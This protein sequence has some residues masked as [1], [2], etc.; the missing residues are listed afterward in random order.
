MALPA[1]L[2]PGAVDGYSPP[3][4]CG[5]VFCRVRSLVHP[6]RQTEDHARARPARVCG[7]VPSPAQDQ[8]P[9]SADHGLREGKMRLG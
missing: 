7:P 9:R 6:L 3:L 8:Q 5:P 4:R 2:A 1:V